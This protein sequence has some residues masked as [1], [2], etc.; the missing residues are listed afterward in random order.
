[1]VG[2]CDNKQEEGNKKLSILTKI[3]KQASNSGWQEREGS[4]FAHK[5]TKFSLSIGIWA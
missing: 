5:E 4:S 2:N 1:M 3:R